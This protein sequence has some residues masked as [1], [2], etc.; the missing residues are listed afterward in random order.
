MKV[1]LLAC[2]L[3]LCGASEAAV[4]T[5][6]RVPLP[7][8]PLWCVSSQPIEIQKDQGGIRFGDL[9]FQQ[10]YLRLQDKALAASIPS[11]GIPFLESA[12][13]AT[14]TAP[15]ASSA[16]APAPVEKV[17]LRVCAIVP[18]GLEAPP[19]GVEAVQRI[20]T[21][22]VAAVCDQANA[23]DCETSLADYL[24]I[25]LKLSDDNIRKVQWRTSQALSPDTSASAI[26][27]GLTDFSLRP[28]Q[29][30]AKQPDPPRNLMIIWAP[31]PK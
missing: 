25:Q 15:P 5:P 16:S 31:V 14:P 1:L 29:A 26:A 23:K 20:A 3:A 17:S 18:P 30:Q 12:S 21:D 9:I 22:V 19:P 8:T 24:K 11:I 7:N 2:S 10:L 13:T 6:V 27:A 4:G 28:L